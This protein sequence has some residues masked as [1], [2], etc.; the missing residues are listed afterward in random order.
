MNEK[1][2]NAARELH[3]MLVKFYDDSDLQPPIKIGD[4][5]HTAIRMYRNSLPDRHLPPG[6]LWSS[7]SL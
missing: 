5:L 7:E 6:V 3:E 1:E 2:L 4:P